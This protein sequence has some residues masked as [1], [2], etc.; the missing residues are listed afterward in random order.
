MSDPFVGPTH[1]PAPALPA[2]WQTWRQDV[3]DGIL[4]MVNLFV[5]TYPNYVRAVYHNRPTSVTGEGPF[6]YIGRIREFIVH[7]SGT[8]QTRFE[9]EIGY[10]DVLVEPRET[11]DRVNT[12]ADFF[13]DL[14]TANA[15][16]FP[17]GILE[18]TG[19][20]DSPEVRQGTSIYLTDVQ[21]SWHFTVLEGRD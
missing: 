3:H 18:E 6:V 5:A 8:R 21:V 16:I 10:V 14:F 17:F 4:A 19:F 13:R 2:A 11:D 12:F 9:G 20:D 1:T 7:D 15:R